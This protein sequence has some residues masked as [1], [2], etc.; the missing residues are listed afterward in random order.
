MHLSFRYELLVQEIKSARVQQKLLAK[1]VAELAR[2]ASTQNA[3]VA[4]DVAALTAE[5]ARVHREVNLSE[6]AVALRVDA[7]VKGHLVQVGRV[8]MHWCSHWVGGVGESRGCSK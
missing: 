5:L 2:N 7:L 3:G 6:D 1:A 4:A 8:D